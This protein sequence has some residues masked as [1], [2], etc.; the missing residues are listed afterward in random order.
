MVLVLT[1]NIK[2]Q[3]DFQGA[4]YINNKA[5]CLLNANIEM[6]ELMNNMRGKRP[7]IL[8]AYKQTD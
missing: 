6:F 8:P 1:G 7:Q 5:Q 3:T 4:S 2:R